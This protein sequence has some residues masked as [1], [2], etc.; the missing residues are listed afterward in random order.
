MLDPVPRTTAQRALHQVFKHQLLNLDTHLFEWCAYPLLYTTPTNSQW[1]SWPYDDIAERVHFNTTT[2]NCLL[3][4]LGTHLKFALI[5]LPDGTRL[6]VSSIQLVTTG[7]TDHLIY[8]YATDQ[9]QLSGQLAIGG[10]A[11]PPTYFSYSTLVN[12]A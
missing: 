5:P 8:T 11:P 2:A 1:R 6:K 3:R 9:V 12:Q 10:P 4:H 7:F